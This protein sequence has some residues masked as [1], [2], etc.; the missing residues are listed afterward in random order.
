VGL[1]QVFL[2]KVIINDLKDI[3][4]F[5][6]GVMHKVRVMRLDNNSP[7]RKLFS[8]IFRHS[9]AGIILGLFLLGTAGCD[10]IPGLGQDEQPLPEATAAVEMLEG[11]TQ[12]ASPACQVADLPVL[13]TDKAQGDL[14]AWAEN[15]DIIAFAAPDNGI[16]GWYSGKL[17]IV[18]MDDPTAQREFSKQR[19]FGDVTWSPGGTQIGFVALRPD[20]NIYTVMALNVETLTAADLIPGMTASTDIWAS[21]KGIEKWE[22]EQNL[23]ITSVCGSDCVDQASVNTNGLVMTEITQLRRNEDHSLALTLNQPEYDAALYPP[24]VNPNWTPDLSKIAFLDENDNLIVFD[25][26]QQGY[27]PFDLTTLT[28]NETKW[29]ADSRY[30]AVRAD[31]HLF[32]Y[33]MQCP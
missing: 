32:I 23:V 16:W 9:A 17:V 33:D 6:E 15:Q 8:R 11:F 29:S 31:G 12:I 28:V 26:D 2:L 7:Y 4:K 1:A 21:Q 19:V 22:D 18:S 14:L 25:R 24:M 3:F 5:R 27:Y 13:Q 30:L 20:G 10:A